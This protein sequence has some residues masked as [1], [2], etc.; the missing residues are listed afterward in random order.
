MN[1]RTGRMVKKTGTIGRA[2][3]VACSQGCEKKAPKAPAPPKAKAPKKKKVKFNVKPAPAPAKPAPKKSINY[4]LSVMPDAVEEL[5]FERIE[6]NHE[7]PRSKAA[8]RERD[9]NL[10]EMYDRLIFNMANSKSGGKVVPVKAKNKAELK[11]I[12]AKVWRNTI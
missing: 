8:I 1:P 9:T 6:E 11:K 2:L 5:L 7:N 10:R 12:W 4:I 3:V